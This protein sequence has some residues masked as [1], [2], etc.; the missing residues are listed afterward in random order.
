MVQRLLDTLIAMPFQDHHPRSACRAVVK[1]VQPIVLWILLSLVPT[2]PRTQ[3][4]RRDVVSVKAHSA[5]C[6]DFDLP[7]LQLAF[8]SLPEYRE[9]KLSLLVFHYNYTYVVRALDPCPLVFGP[10]E[11][12]WV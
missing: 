5:L 8:Q 9:L 2:P 3:S 1:P 12:T 6:L 11:S 10:I 4:T 7:S